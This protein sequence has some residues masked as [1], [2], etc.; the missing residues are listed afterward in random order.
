MSAAISTPIPRREVTAYYAR[1]LK[2]DVPLALDLIADIVLNP[3]FD[4]P[5]SRSSAA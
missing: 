2:E 5:R 3:A 4:P 1:V